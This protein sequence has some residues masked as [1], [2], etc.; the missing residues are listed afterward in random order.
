M[1]K[2]VYKGKKLQVTEEEYVRPDGT[3]SVYERV[4]LPTAILIIPFL[5]PDE[6]L[7]IREYRRHEIPAVRL[8]LV[9][10]CYENELSLEENV[11]HELQ[12]EAG[13]RAEKI[14][15]YH[16]FKRR[17]IVTDHKM[18]AIASGLTKSKI[19]NPD[20]EETILGIETIK[21]DDLYDYVIAGNYAAGETSFVLLKM[22]HDLKIGKLRI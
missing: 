12:E 2:E 18:Y 14:F 21:L 20:G 22:L 16:E 4:Y 9:T 7:F 19:P 17:N 1:E 10:G 8:K 11:N 3:E 13:Y 6:I 5:T 15:L